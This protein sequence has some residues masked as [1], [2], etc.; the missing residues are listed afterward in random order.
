[1]I[2]K[3]NQDHIEAL[4]KQLDKYREIIEAKKRILELNEAERDYKNGRDDLTGELSD[5]Q[6]QLDALANDDSREALV[7]RNELLEQMKKSKRSWLSINM[8]IPM[9]SSKMLWIES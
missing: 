4:E 8:I 6:K 2:Q 9:T 5:L 3:E 1:M 7:K